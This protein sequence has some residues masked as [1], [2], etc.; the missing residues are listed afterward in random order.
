MCSGIPA[1][2]GPYHFIRSLNIRAGLL[3][4]LF[5]QIHMAVAVSPYQMAVLGH[6]LYQPFIAPVYFLPPEKN[7]AFTWRFLRPSKSF[8]V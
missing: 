3:C 6:L 8:F 7:E 2:N 4:R 1:S 5:C